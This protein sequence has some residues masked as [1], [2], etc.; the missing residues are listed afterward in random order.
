MKCSGLRRTLADKVS[1]AGQLRSLKQA[2]STSTQR[3]GEPALPHDWWFQDHLITSF[4]SNINIIY[5]H[6]GV[7]PLTLGPVCKLRPQFWLLLIHRAFF[8]N[9]WTSPLYTM[10]AAGKWCQ[11]L[12][13]VC[14]CAYVSGSAELMNVS[15]ATAIDQEGFTWCV[16][17]INLIL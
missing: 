17:L 16:N 3:S 4:V 1:D 15:K 13:R 9:E 10:R 6:W 2:M 7:K 8:W 12:H 5:E 14:V 11:M